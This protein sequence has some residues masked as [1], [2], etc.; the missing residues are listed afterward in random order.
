MVEFID[1]SSDLQTKRIQDLEV[2]NIGYEDCRPGYGYGPTLRPYHLIHFVIRG[3]GKLMIRDHTFSIKGGEAFLIPAEQVAYYEASRTDP[4]SY[5]WIGFTGNQAVSIS[6]EFMASTPDRYVLRDLDVEKYRDVLKE[7]AELDEV[8][9][10]N[11]YL[12]SSILM[13]TAA[14][15]SEEF[16][17]RGYVGQSQTLADEI[18]FFFDSKYTENLQMQEIAQSF[19]IHPNYMNHIFRTKY[20]ISPKQYLTGLKIDKAKIML[21]TTDLPVQLIASSLGFADQLSFSRTFKGRVGMA[22]T[23]YRKRYSDR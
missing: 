1:S 2:I 20:G 5:T 9:V 13:R 6:R 8:T 11:H 14:L 15:L 3:Q 18:K 17:D 4:W 7:G 12:C 21:S 16:R 22:P 19:G 23:E 10:P